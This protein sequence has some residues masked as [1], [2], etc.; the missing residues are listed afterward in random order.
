MCKISTLLLPDIV[1]QGVIIRTSLGCIFYAHNCRRH[2]DGTLIPEES[3][4]SLL[5]FMIF[6]QRLLM[7]ISCSTDPDPG[8]FECDFLGDKVMLKE[9]VLGL[10]KLYGLPG[11][12]FQEQTLA[13]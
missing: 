8:Q 2:S 5:S 1:Y 10:N 6:K 4:N 3:D 12:N 9:K 7:A 13:A 11:I